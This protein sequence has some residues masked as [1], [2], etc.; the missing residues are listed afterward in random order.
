MNVFF[1]KQIISALMIV[2]DLFYFSSSH[3]LP[4]RLLQISFFYRNLIYVYLKKYLALYVER[5]GYEFGFVLVTFVGISYF[6]SQ[7]CIL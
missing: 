5:L 2:V 3:I 1:L 7:I 4:N 6:A